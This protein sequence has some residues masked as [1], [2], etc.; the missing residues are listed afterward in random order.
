MGLHVC[1]RLAGGEALTRICKRPGFP[2]LSVIYQ[3]A[4]TSPEFAELFEQARRMYA[5]TLVDQAVD[6]A[7]DDG[8]DWRDVV[9][10]D[11]TVE[12]VFN[13]EHA[14]RSKLR[15]DVRKWVAG[16]MDRHTYGES[17][18]VDINAKIMTINLTDEELDKRLAAASAKLI[19]VQ[20]QP[21][22][23]KGN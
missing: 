19:D 16:K 2:D 11:G 8:G 21:L 12:R 9:R 22:D 3:W 20:T 17:K 18:Q 5:A 14:T 6:I 10:K 23:N 1:E 15:V 4:D 7:D 13:H